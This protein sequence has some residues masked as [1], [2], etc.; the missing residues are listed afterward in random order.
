MQQ[1]TPVWRA[2]LAWECGLSVVAVLQCTPVLE[3][4]SVS[5]NFLVKLQSK[6]ST[7]RSILMRPSNTRYS[8]NLHHKESSKITKRSG[9]RR[10]AAALLLLLLI[11]AACRLRSAWSSLVVEQ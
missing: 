11:S 2:Y 1:C 6:A 4:R 3:G 10:P 7:A 9:D 5:F 8:V